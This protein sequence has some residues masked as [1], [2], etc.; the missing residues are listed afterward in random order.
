LAILAVGRLYRTVSQPKRHCIWDAQIVLL[1]QG[2]FVEGAE[3]LIKEAEC[4]LCPDDEAANVSTRSELEKVQP[5]DIDKFNTRQVTEGLDNAVVLLEYDKRAT[6]LTVAAV[7]HFALSCTEFARVGDLGNIRVCIQGLEESDSLLGFLEGL[8]CAL[9]DKR[10][11][12]NL[13]DT[14]TAGENKGWERGSCEC[15]DGSESAL[16]LVDL[17]VPFA[18]SL[19]GG[20][21]ATAT[22]HVSKG[23]LGIYC[24]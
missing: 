12:S 16:I 5:L 19:G 15:G 18:P 8:S 22:A 1:V 14:V 10:N 6:T 24:Q 21:H 11:L 23:S 9:N 13:L 3:H 17:D 20:E 7:A 2:G 4:T